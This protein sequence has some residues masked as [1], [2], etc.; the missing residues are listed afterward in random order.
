M[1]SARRP[2][3]RRGRDRAAARHARTATWSSPSV[4]TDLPADS[5]A[6][7]QEIFGPVA[8]LIPFD[9]EEEAVR[10]ANDTPYGLSGA[11]HTGDIER[12]VR[13]AKRI[14]TGMFHINDGTVHDE[15]IVP[16]GGE[17]NSGLGPAERRADGG[18][19]HHHQVDLDPA[20]PQRFPF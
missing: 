16:F 3:R 1:H 18:G 19:V 7:A 13:F 17:K 4:L 14:D 11:V 8:L 2:D 9:G 15:P 10:I 6:P 20:R 12:G 5:R